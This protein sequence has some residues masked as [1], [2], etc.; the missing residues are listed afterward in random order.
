M[1]LK[2]S[3]ND[4]ESKNDNWWGTEKNRL[5]LYEILK[6]SEYKSY[7]ED[8]YVKHYPSLP[9]WVDEAPFKKM[10]RYELFTIICYNVVKKDSNYYII[11]KKFVTP[12]C[13]KKYK[14]KE[15]MMECTPDIIVDMIG[16][17]K[18]NYTYV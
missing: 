12:L 3:K 9:K 7:F 14:T 18:K 16:E 17:K 11:P 4:K 6:S 5:R 13:S 8:I 1:G 15:N 2:Q 10:L